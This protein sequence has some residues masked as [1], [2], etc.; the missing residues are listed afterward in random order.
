M[1]NTSII[2]CAALLLIAAVIPL[3]AAETGPTRLFILSGQS[4]MEGLD[5]NESFTPTLKKAFPNDNLILVKYAKSGQSILRWLAD[6][7]PASGAP[8]DIRKGKLGDMYKT[9]MEMVAKELKD[10]P[11]P[12]SIVFVWMQGEAD[13][14]DLDHWGVYQA[15]LKT[16]IS[17]MRNDLK[18]PDMAFVIGRISDYAE[19]PEGTKVVREAQVAVAEADPLGAWFDT[20]DLNGSNNGLHY[21]G[22]GKVKLG[23]RFAEKAIKHINSPATKN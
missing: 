18:R 4:N 6:W 11:K 17:N 22:E 19:H 10:K 9:L 7:K 21:L 16:L 1:K 8:P 14:H 2:V 3:Q 13:T 15:S 5:P 23:E 12:D 20:D